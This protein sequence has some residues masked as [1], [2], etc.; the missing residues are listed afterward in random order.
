MAIIIVH[1]IRTDGG[2]LEAFGKRLELLGHDVK[3]YQYELRHFWSYWNK[4]NMRRDGASLLHDDIYVEGDDVIAH[5]NGQLVIESAVK[6]GAKFGKIII[7]SGA[8]TSDKFV[9]PND[10][11][12]E[13]HWF[14]NTKDKAVWIG[15]KIPWHVFGKAAR[16]GYAGVEDD[17]HSN[18][19]YRYAKWFSMDHSFWF[20]ACIEPILKL[21][22]KILKG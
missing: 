16:V 11:M 5:S 20:K 3:Y 12:T 21:T 22:D 17:R 19:K 15:S 4:A 7:F 6:Q 1:G 13:C 10:S 2:L 9:W 8:G 14:V 18:Y